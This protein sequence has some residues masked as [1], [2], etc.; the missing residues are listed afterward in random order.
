M[1]TALIHIL[2]PKSGKR[3]SQSRK[4]PDW[5][6][7]SVVIESR[8]VHSRQTENGFQLYILLRPSPES[9]NGNRIPFVPLLK[10]ALMLVYLE[11]IDDGPERMAQSDGILDVRSSNASMYRM[12]HYP[13][14]IIQGSLLLPLFK[15]PHRSS[16]RSSLSS[17]TA[18][19]PFRSTIHTNWLLQAHKALPTPFYVLPQIASRSNISPP[20]F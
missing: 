8:Q 4:L 16:R 11:K 1:P 14:S 19:S 20:S 18:T 2:C 10:V 12:I 17:C 5:G 9:L 15:S 13:P 6:F 7:D 3:L